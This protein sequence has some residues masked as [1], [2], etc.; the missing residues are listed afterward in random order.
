MFYGA[1][2]ISNSSKIDVSNLQFTNADNMFVKWDGKI[3][4]PATLTNLTSANKA[5]S[6]IKP[7]GDVSETS[8]ITMNTFSVSFPSTLTSANNIFEK[9]IID[10]PAISF[11]DCNNLLYKTD[12]FKDCTLRTTGSIQI[13]NAPQTLSSYY[14]YL[15]ASSASMNYSNFLYGID[16]SR[17]AVVNF[18]AEAPDN[19]SINVSSLFENSKFNQFNF[20]QFNDDDLD[21]LIISL[22]MDCML[23]GTTS[24]TINIV[25]DDVISDTTTNVSAIAMFENATIKNLTFNANKLNNATRIFKNASINLINDMNIADV[26]IADE[27]FMNT[28]ISSVGYFE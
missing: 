7:F 27:A 14:I 6:E 20:N 4:F 22:T 19:C 10:N 9:S 23:K 13:T 24:E 28:G 26:G 8:Q 15:P 2:A 3:V 5:F 17:A 11:L 18:V 21:D 25:I 12:M 16:A 1:K